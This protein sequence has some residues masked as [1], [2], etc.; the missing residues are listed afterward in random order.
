MR[1]N[2]ANQLEECIRA[3]NVYQSSP[4][5]Q[6]KNPDNDWVTNLEQIPTDWY[7]RIDH[8]IRNAPRAPSTSSS[9]QGTNTS[10][11]LPSH[12]FKSNGSTHFSDSHQTSSVYSISSSQKT[13]RVLSRE[14][15]E[16]KTA[17]QNLQIE[18]QR[19]QSTIAQKVGSMAQPAQQGSSQRA[20]GTAKFRGKLKE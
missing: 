16:E 9:I 18:L 5:H 3:H 4:T 17:R 1:R 6:R 12:L 13:T 19:V 2:L 11:S 8:Y 20:V 14:L 7:E 10:F 15:A